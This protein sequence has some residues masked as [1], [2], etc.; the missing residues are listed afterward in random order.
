MTQRLTYISNWINFFFYFL[1]FWQLRLFLFAGYFTLNFIILPFLLSLWL[2]WLLWL[3]DCLFL[4]VFFKYLLF[5]FNF[6]RSLFAIHICCFW[7]FIIYYLSWCLLA[8]Y[9]FGLYSSLFLLST[10]IR[11]NMFAPITIS[12]FCFRNNRNTCWSPTSFSR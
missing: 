3:C 11:I 1:T 10:F 7:L 5:H 9:W 4:I 8:W 12:I 2:L 6:S